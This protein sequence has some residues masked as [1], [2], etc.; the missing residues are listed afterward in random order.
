MDVK[1]KL[2]ISFA[3]LSK[4]E[5]QYYRIF[6][7][8]PLHPAAAEEEKNVGETFLAN[9]GRY[10]CRLKNMHTYKQKWSEVRI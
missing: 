4:E 2:N 1:I 6:S 7:F 3:L 9:K 5:N 8:A 10:L